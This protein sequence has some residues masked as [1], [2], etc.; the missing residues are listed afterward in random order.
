MKTVILAIAI[1]MVTACVPLKRAY[2]K[3]PIGT[4]NNALKIG[5]SVTQMVG[6]LGAARMV[7]HPEWANASNDAGTVYYYDCCIV[8]VINNKVAKIKKLKQ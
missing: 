5:M 4:I 3:D 6:V 1:M 8:N 7:S 2:D